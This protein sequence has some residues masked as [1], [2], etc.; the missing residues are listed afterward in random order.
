M[1]TR[2]AKFVDRT[3]GAVLLFAVF[4][5]LFRYYTTAELA[6]FSA[7]AAAACV[8]LVLCAVG[9]NRDG[10]RELDKKAEEMF[11]DFLFE[12]DDCPAKKLAAALRA[13][14]VEATVKAGAVYALGTAAFFSFDRPLD[15]GRAARMVARAKR[16]GAL[17]AVVFCKCQPQSTVSVKDFPLKAVC[18][19]EV[20][21]LFA[22]LDALPKR[23]FEKPVG[24]R[25]AAFSKALSSDRILRYLAL[26]AALFAV[27]LLFG[28][29]LIPFVCATVSAALFAASV[30][31]NAVKKIKAVKAEKRANGE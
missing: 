14:N 23:T 2:F 15:E 22:S 20:Y 24:S 31:F 25:F 11:Y 18:G 9:K 10:K 29:S 1:K 3:V 30:V 8:V 12:S 26:S 16:N 17:R 19:D 7:A 6:A 4:T 27:S 21:K 13:K 5:A 28:F